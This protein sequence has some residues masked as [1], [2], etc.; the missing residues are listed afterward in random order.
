MARAQE[1]FVVV[2]G[3]LWLWSL[4]EDRFS[5]TIRTLDFYHVSQ[6]LWDLAHYFSAPHCFVGLASKYFVGKEVF[7]HGVSWGCGQISVGSYGTSA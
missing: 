5:G 3:A 2:D 4:I 1:V 6:R 7:G